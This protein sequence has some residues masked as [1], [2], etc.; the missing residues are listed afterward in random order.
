MKLSFNIAKASC[1]IC[2]DQTV[3]VYIQI[4]DE[5]GILK[6]MFKKEIK[7]VKEVLEKL[8]NERVKGKESKHDY[9][10]DVYEFSNGMYLCYNGK[11][12]IDNDEIVDSF[13]ISPSKNIERLGL[14]SCKEVAP[15]LNHFPQNEQYRVAYLELSNMIYEV[16]LRS[17]INEVGRNIIF[18]NNMKIVRH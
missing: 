16:E 5:L 2:K 15:K 12:E 8:S 4:F 13:I 17:Q 7:R 10:F 14:K 11:K 9:S 18:E 1:N 3:V 6:T